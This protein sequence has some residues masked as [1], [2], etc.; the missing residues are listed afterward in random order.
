MNDKFGPMQV[1]VVVGPREQLTW[2]GSN[3][4]NWCIKVNNIRDRVR[5]FV[6]LMRIG[7]PYMLQLQAIGISVFFLPC[8]NK[9][10]KRQIQMLSKRIKS[11]S[12]MSSFKGF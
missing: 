9:D 6:A 7:G 5:Y 3:Q 4:V 1:V 2:K 11:K 10:R 12:K 8:Q